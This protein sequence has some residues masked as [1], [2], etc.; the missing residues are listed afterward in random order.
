M[1]KRISLEAFVALGCVALMS[2]ACDGKEDRVSKSPTISKTPPIP[3]VARDKPALA[4]IAPVPVE[5]LVLFILVE[6]DFV[7]GSPVVDFGQL[8]QWLSDM[9]EVG[10]E[11][12]HNQADL[13]PKEQLLDE[14]AQCVGFS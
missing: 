1:S 14:E 11:V 2:V 5:P 7:L 6:L 8:L 9:H 13:G 10:I 3:S 12:K 4:N